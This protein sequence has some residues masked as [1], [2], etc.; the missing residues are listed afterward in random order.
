MTGRLENMQIES[1]S[2]NADV[3]LM[4]TAFGSQG[5]PD[6][7]GSPL[8][9]GHSLGTAHGCPGPGPPPPPSP[10]AAPCGQ[11]LVLLA[12]NGLARKTR[13]AHRCVAM[14]LGLG[15]TLGAPGSFKNSWCLGPSTAQF[16]WATPASSAGTCN[17]G[18][19]ETWIPGN[20]TVM[21]SVLDLMRK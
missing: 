12:C 7:Q 17:R 8:P 14:A 3:P 2:H 9:M 4:K 1:I 11:A 6:N 19:T 21:R 13:V 18:L 20:H 5:S 15:C 16:S 10:P